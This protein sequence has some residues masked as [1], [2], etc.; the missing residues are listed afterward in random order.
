MAAQN[1]SALY[2]LIY[3]CYNP[4]AGWYERGVAAYTGLNR[5]DPE[6]IWSFQG[7]AFVGWKSVDQ[8]D[9][10]RGFVEATPEGK[11]V[12]IDMST[13]G[14]GEWEKWRN[15]SYWGARFIWTTLHDFGGSDSLRG[16]CCSPHL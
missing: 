14:E 12:V 4:A 3:G 13:N 6:A 7:W 1:F 8:G 10:L 11:F 9:S 15:A 5:T 16:D 2:L